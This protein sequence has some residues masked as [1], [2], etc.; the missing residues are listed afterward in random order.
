MRSLR[1][2]RALRDVETVNVAGNA[3]YAAVAKELAAQLQEMLGE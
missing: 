1:E 2:F 3:S